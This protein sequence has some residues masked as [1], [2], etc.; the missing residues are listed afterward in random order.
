M[1]GASV[2]DMAQGFACRSSTYADAWVALVLIRGP[3]DGAVA[4]VDFSPG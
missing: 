4:A 1:S 3:E 2:A